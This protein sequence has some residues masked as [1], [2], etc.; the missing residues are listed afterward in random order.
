MKAGDSKT[1][2]MDCDGDC[3]VKDTEAKSYSG[4]I[5]LFGSD[6]YIRYSDGEILTTGNLLCKGF[7]LGSSPVTCLD[8]T[9]AKTDPFYFLVISPPSGLTNKNVA[10]IYN[11]SNVNSIK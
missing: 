2:T 9:K 7:G 8:A 1:L 4:K 3:D 6:A 5:D 11:V 10:F